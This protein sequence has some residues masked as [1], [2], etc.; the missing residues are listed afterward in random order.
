MRVNRPDEPGYAGIPTF[1]R[2]P[3]VLEPGELDG[4][5]VVI[6]GAPTDELVTH[7]PGARF[8]PRAI[9]ES[10]PLGV[11]ARPNMDVGVDPFVVLKVV[12]FGD[13]VPNPGYPLETHA[14]VRES[15]KLIREKGAVPVVLGGDHA[16]AHPDVGAVSQVVGAESLGL[17]HFDAHADDGD[18]QMLNHGTPLRKLVEEGSILGKNIVQV[19]LRGY[20]PSPEEFEW[21]REQGFRW[22]LMKEVI[23]RGI[24]AVT[25]EV[26]SAM[27]GL[28]HVFLSVD[29]DVCDP[30]FAP[31]TGFPE[32]GGM[33]ARE[34]LQ[35]VRRIALELPL[36]GMEIVEVAPPYD[37]ADITAL[38]ANRVVMEVLSGIALRKSGRAPRP[39]LSS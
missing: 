4:A 28:D 33:Q 22:H 18:E 6:V 31:G 36:T 10:D 17:I 15:V 20:W 14:G 27:S 12:D 37:H 39:E 25:D 38:L 1:G 11:M 9:R 5:D 30:A 16:L 32:P 7:R 29:I 24:E 19:G 13:V 21:A 35:S 26:L 2:V 34:L 8:G 3:L 23:E